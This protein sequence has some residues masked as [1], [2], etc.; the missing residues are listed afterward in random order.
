MI[1]F[2][3]HDFSSNYDKV[4][5]QLEECALVTKTTVACI[6]ILQNEVNNMANDEARIRSAY[7]SLVEIYMNCM[8]ID[9]IWLPL[10]RKAF[11]TVVNDP[12]IRDHCK[13]YIKYL[14]ILKHL[15]DYEALVKSTIQMLE[16][17]PNEF[18]PLEMICWVYVNKQ[19]DIQFSFE[20]SFVNYSQY[21]F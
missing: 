1:Y 5:K 9:K 11:E 6:E 13:V 20:V 4:H 18:I 21:E 10:F 8:N 17:Y 15:K 14:K 19:N 16:I 12:T 2:F 7:K 3:L